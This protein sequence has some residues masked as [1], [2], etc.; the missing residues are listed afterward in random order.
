M[1]TLTRLATRR[2]WHVIAFWGLLVALCLPFALQLSDQLKAGGFNDSEGEGALGQQVLEQAFDQAPNSLLV[3][4]HQPD[5]DVTEAADIAADVARNFPHVAAVADYRQDPEW[6]SEDRS[7]TLLQVGLNVDNTTAQNKVEPLRDQI[8]ATLADRGVEVNVTG[9]PALDYDLNVQSQRDALLAEMIAFPLLIVVLFLVF[10]SVAS[11]LV[12]LVLAGLALVIA[13]AV[14]YLAAQVTDLSILFTNGVSLIGLAVAVDYSLFIVKRYRDELLHTDDAT[15]AVERAMRTAGR[16]VV[17]SG[18]AVAVSLLA[19]F[20]PQ[21]MV[22]S[23]IGLAGVLVT[24]VALAMTMTLLPAVLRVLGTRINWGSIKAWQPT[25]HRQGFRFTT[26]LLRRPVPLLLTLVAL[27]ALLAWPMTDIR[28]Q[29]PVA[30]ASILPPEADSRQ[31]IERLQTDL[32]TSGLFPVQVV[33]RTTP[34]GNPQHLLD[35]T[36][37]VANLANS[38]PQAESVLA[39]TDMGL[40]R[41]ALLA[42]ASGNTDQLPKSAAKAFSDLWSQQGTTYITRVVVAPSSSP[43]SDATHDLVDALRSQLPQL[44]SEDVSAQVTGA[45]AQGTDFDNAVV[46]S[47]PV[48]IVAVALATFALLTFAFRSWRL[49]LLALALNALVV[50]SSL[51]ILTLVFQGTLDTPI[52]SVTPLLLFAIMFGISMDYMV[53]M[54]SRMRE[55]FLEEQDHDHAVTAGIKNTASQVN[56]AAL[57]MVAVFVS[58]GSAKISVVQQLGLGLATAVILD[59]LVIRLLVMPAALR[60]LGPRVWGRVHPLP[61]PQTSPIKELAGTR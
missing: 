9:A 16:A 40:P 28:L 3:V 45:T 24:L 50:G 48:V 56:G 31:G 33:L 5:H 15:L 29:V 12:P 43:D 27:F 30:S 14:G 35:T 17:F 21:I 36:H 42:A 26:R 49:P 2:P 6:L 19:L 11:L 13:Q 53:I 46:K 58:F 22:F 39:V 41:E 60:I 38:Q 20:I 57:I 44:T 61:T 1:T 8:T 18:L 25:R 47:F 54:I 37:D 32:D 52:N 23:S 51:G 55:N 10:R 34:E 7:T 4:L 59:A